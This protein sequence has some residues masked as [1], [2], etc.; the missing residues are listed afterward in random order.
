MY[1][2]I[3]VW[4][5]SKSFQVFASLI[6]TTNDTVDVLHTSELIQHRHYSTKQFD[7]K[8]RLYNF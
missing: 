3:G 1:I 2:N 7:F 4:H 8:L 5:Y 6:L